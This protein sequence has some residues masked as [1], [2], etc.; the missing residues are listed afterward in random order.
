[1]SEAET[2]IKT[3][4]FR[5]RHFK[6][7]SNRRRTPGPS[8]PAIASAFEAGFKCPRAFSVVPRQNESE[9][10]LIVSTPAPGL[11]LPLPAQSFRYLS[12]DM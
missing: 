1:M 9:V 4:R 2:G 11:D 10:D 3:T 7:G 8:Q 6:P 5:H 12:H